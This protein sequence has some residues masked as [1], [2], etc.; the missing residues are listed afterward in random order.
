MVEGVNQWRCG[1]V[2]WPVVHSCI[3]HA[4]LMVAAEHHRIV[5]QE[6]NVCEGG[7]AGAI[8]KPPRAANDAKAGKGSK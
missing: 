4:V 7:E 5:H 6:W 8:E 3:L 2:R 1:A